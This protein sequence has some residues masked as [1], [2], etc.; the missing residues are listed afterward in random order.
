MK[1]NV[2][3]SGMTGKY[4]KRN[5]T[6]CKCGKHSYPSKKM[7][8]EFLKKYKDVDADVNIW[9]I[10]SWETGKVKIYLELTYEVQG[11]NAKH[12]SN[13]FRFLKKYKKFKEKSKRAKIIVG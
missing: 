7:F 5:L 1:I 8:V 4:D 2:E 6:I 13:V 3:P 10:E 12:Y 11:K 9:S